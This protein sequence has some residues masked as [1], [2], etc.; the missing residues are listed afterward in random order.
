MAN[1]AECSEK[2]G[3][4][5]AVTVGGES[6]CKVHGE[7]KQAELDNEKRELEARAAR[8]IVTTTPSLEGRPVSHYLEPVSAF[9]LV[10]LEAGADFGAAWA[11]WAG[12]EHAKQASR[13]VELERAV[14]ASLRANALEA[15][16]DAV[17]GTRIEHD[18]VVSSTGK[19]AVLAP[20]DVQT[21]RFFVRATGTA[22]K[23]AAA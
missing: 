13:F 5:G 21:R 8:V 3:F 12:G 19:S 14:L 16:A 1:C 2:L 20:G 7:A 10:T 22:V 6:Y 4:F 15:G 9:A 23:L 17:V 18:L 11:E